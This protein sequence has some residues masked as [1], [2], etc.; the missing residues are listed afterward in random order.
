MNK[1]L[2]KFTNYLDQSAKEIEQKVVASVEKREGKVP[3]LL[4]RAQIRQYNDRKNM[5]RML[6]VPKES[7]DMHGELFI[8]FDIL[9]ELVIAAKLKSKEIF[10]VVFHL[11]AKNIGA[12]VLDS[13]VR[14]FD[15]KKIEKYDFS[16]YKYLNKEV[17]LGMVRTDEYGRLAATPR[18]ELSKEEREKLEEFEKFTMENP[19]DLTGIIDKHK[20]LKEHYFD[21]IDSFDMEDIEIII[22]ILGD[23]KL[24]E[25]HI[26]VIRELLVQKVD[27]RSEIDTPV[28]VSK[29]Q[30]REVKPRLSEK[31]YNLLAREL[32]RF[33]DLTNMIVVQPLSFELQIY[34]VSLMIRMEIPEVIIRKALKVMSK[35]NSSLEC[36]PITEFSNFYEKLQYYK[37]VP[38]LREAVQTMMECLQEMFITSDDDYLFYKEMLEAE[39]AKAKNEVPNTFDYEIEEANKLIKGL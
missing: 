5:S 3:D 35:S 6:K 10:T 28:I 31:E 8:Q 14:F 18:E 4:E 26:N 25:E 20:L 16:S 1:T 39:L 19:E 33:F 34:C 37:N 36:N 24:I 2:L 27:K 17:I 13:S 29:E 11:L 15:I 7:W 30:I 21:K 22:S 9:S 38:S 23:F 32:R 12:N